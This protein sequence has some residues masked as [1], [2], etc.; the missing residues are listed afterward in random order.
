MKLLWV[1]VCGLTLGT[2]SLANADDAKGPKSLAEIA[3]T[4]KV[5]EVAN[6]YIANISC[7]ELKVMSSNVATIVPWSGAN[8]MEQPADYRVLWTAD[9]GPCQ[10]K[11]YF[12]VKPELAMLS[13]KVTPEGRFFVDVKHS[14]PVEYIKDAPKIGFNKITSVDKDK[15]VISALCN[16]ETIDIPP[17]DI[18][19][20]PAICKAPF[21]LTLLKTE[22]SNYPNR[23]A[24]WQASGKNAVHLGLAAPAELVNGV[25]TEGQITHLSTTKQPWVETRT[26]FVTHLRY[27]GRADWVFSYQPNTNEPGNQC[28]LSYKSGDSHITD[29]IPCSMTSDTLDIFKPLDDTTLFINV[30]S[31]RG[32]IGYIMSVKKDKTFSI[33]TLPYMSGDEDSLEVEIEGNHFIASSSEDS[34]VIDKMSDNGVAIKSYTRISK[35]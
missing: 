25:I 22:Y 8:S 33:V 16:V 17:R 23:M 2:H 12:K 18:K 7:S 14:Y 32:G 15:I 13:V 10:P 3:T 5:L 28:A 27:Q 11:Q 4:A 9:N 26:Q 34:Y 24:Y 21:D 6:S 20:K 35:Q 31:E 29:I 30:S 19:G 1:V